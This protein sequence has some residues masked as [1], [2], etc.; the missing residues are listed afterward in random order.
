MSTSPLE[1]Q[2][3]VNQVKL[4]LFCRNSDDGFVSFIEDNRLD[5]WESSLPGFISIVYQLLH[6]YH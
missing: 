4:D 5:H 2:T 3:L 1:D 6:L